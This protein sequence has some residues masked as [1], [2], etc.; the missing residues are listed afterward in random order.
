MNV[1]DKL[2]LKCVK[3]C[4]RPK[5]AKPILK[6]IEGFILP[7]LKIYIVTVIKTCVQLNDGQVDH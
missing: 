4:K 1:I 7:C 2:I 3:N 5:R 6:R